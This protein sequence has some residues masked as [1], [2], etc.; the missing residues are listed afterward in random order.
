[1]SDHYS[2]ARILVTENNSQATLEPKEAY[3][4][5]DGQIILSRQY[6]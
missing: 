4:L 6:P 5:S 2:H 1:M 3:Q